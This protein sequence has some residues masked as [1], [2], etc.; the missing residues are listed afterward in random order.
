[1]YCKSSKYHADFGTSGNWNVSLAAETEHIF[2]GNIV[3]V[4]YPTIKLCCIERTAI[5]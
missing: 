3:P 2:P 1:M 5:I 4:E